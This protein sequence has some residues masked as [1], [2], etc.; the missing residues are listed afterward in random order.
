M[1][2]SILFCAQKLTSGRPSR[3]AAAE[4]RTQVLATDEA[5]L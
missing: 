3:L 2:Y 1:P 5:A 4:D